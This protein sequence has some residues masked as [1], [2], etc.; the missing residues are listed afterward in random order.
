MPVNFEVGE[1][2]NV[3]DIPG[4]CQ[5]SVTVDKQPVIFYMD[6]KARYVI[7]GSIIELATKKNL[8]LEEQKVLKR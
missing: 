3:K 6:K 5:V 7:S 8:T 2:K 4:I 1:I